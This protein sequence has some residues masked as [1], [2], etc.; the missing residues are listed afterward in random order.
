MFA[1]IPY[2]SL[3]YT[4]VP[5]ERLAGWS[6]NTL[7]LKTNWHC[8]CVASVMEGRTA[9]TDLTS[10]RCAVRSPPLCLLI[11]SLFVCFLSFFYFSSS[12][13]SFCS[14]SLLFHVPILG[15]TYLSTQNQTRTWMFVFW[16]SSGV[17]S[18]WLVPG[19]SPGEA[20]G[21]SRDVSFFG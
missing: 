4:H 6:S 5:N 12:L 20:P 15:K 1:A 8:P 19:F 11:S 7:S 17:V 14:L 18:E 21:F 3:I 2:Y 9:R 16:G 10:T 13:C